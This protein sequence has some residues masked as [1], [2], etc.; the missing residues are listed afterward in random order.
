MNHKLHYKQKNNWKTSFIKELKGKPKI[1]LDIKI[2]PGHQKLRIYYAESHL[3]GFILME[4]AL[5]D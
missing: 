2:P 3:G 5:F 1:K 4:L